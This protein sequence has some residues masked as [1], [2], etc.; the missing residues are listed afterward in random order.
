MVGSSP[1]SMVLVTKKVLIV[2]NELWFF[3]S[4]RLPIGVACLS[5]H[6]RGFKPWSLIPEKW[7]C[8]VLKIEEKLLP[9]LGRLM[10]FRL[11]V[12]LEKEG[13]T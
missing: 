8:R 5:I 2:V 9:F 13:N 4:H 11:M 3:L 10:A 7:V 12:V 1:L 6:C